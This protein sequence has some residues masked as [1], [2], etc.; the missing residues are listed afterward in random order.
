MKF[1]VFASIILVALAPAGMRRPGLSRIERALCFGDIPM[2][3]V[4]R[5]QAINMIRQHRLNGLGQEI[6]GWILI[7]L[8]TAFIIY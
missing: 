1:M 8:V 4:S 2:S 5:M 7:I 3:P 6:F